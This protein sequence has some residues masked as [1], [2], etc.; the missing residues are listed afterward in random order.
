MTLSTLLRLAEDLVKLL[1]GAILKEKG[2]G[3][4][5]LWRE[6]AWGQ[7]GATPELKRSHSASD[8]GTCFLNLDHDLED[9]STHLSQKKSP[10]SPSFQQKCPTSQNTGCITHFQADSRLQI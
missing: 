1:C 5:T 2:R 9:F 8:V 10:A 4:G 6:G 7:G 3:E